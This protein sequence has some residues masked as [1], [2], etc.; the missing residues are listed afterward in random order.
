MPPVGGQQPFN[1]YHS[2]NTTHV[3]SARTFP[4][5]QQEA[6]QVMPFRPSFDP[7]RT[8]QQSTGRANV[9]SPYSVY[10][11]VKH[12]ELKHFQKPQQPKEL[13]TIQAST[14]SEAVIHS[15]PE[16]RAM[17]QEQR[18]NVPVYMPDLTLP[19]RPPVP[20][21]PQENS[22]S[23]SPL[24]SCEPEQPDSFVRSQLSFSW[25]R[26][27]NSSSSSQ[28]S[29]DHKSHARQQARSEEDIA[30]TNA[31]LSR[32]DPGA[33]RRHQTLDDA[34]VTILPGSGVMRYKPVRVTPLEEIQKKLSGKM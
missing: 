21:T 15:D 8:A 23:N 2:A 26:P 19:P 30:A 29:H 24:T 13:K 11:Y 34:S 1:Q 6:S 9:L 33:F 20:F 17:N 12:K 7:S 31:L 22:S 5:V 4:V 27:A 18:P 25:P 32:L 10:R 14:Q 28:Q 16:C 3:S